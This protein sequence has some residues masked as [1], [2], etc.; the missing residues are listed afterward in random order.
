[1]EEWKN[2]RV[3][4]ATPQVIQKDLE[5]KILPAKLVK[6]IVIDEAHKALGNHAYAVVIIDTTVFCLYC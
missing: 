5:A 3:I 1:M 6:C 4:F 2:K